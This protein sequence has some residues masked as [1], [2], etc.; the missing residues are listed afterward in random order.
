MD[1]SLFSPAAL[2]QDG[3]AQ[4]EYL[5]SSCGENAALCDLTPLKMEEQLSVPNVSIPCHD[6]QRDKKKRYTVRAQTLF[7]FSLNLTFASRV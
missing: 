4:V 5:K 2:T 3:E 7:W 6:E 1:S